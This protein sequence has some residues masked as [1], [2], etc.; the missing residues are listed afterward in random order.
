MFLHFNRT[1]FG[2]GYQTD[3][4]LRDTSDDEDGMPSEDAVATETDNDGGMIVE[5]ARGHV[6]LSL[7]VMMFGVI[8]MM[9]V[10]S[11]YLWRWNGGNISI[12]ICVCVCMFFASDPHD[13]KIAMRRLP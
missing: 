3:S 9:G 12:S 7:F 6:C 4:S 10:L 2:V 5:D 1:C 8:L 11:W 13:L